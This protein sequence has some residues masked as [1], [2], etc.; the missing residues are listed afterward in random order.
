MPHLVTLLIV[1]FF[2]LI[3][4]SDYVDTLLFLPLLTQD[5]EWFKWNICKKCSWVN[6]QHFLCPPQRLYKNKGYDKFW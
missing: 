6:M 2:S 5:L 4:F 3:N 1:F